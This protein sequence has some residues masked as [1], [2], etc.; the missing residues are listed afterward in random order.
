MFFFGGWGDVWNEFHP[1]QYRL[2]SHW[3]G[4]LLGLQRANIVNQEWQHQYYIYM[5][6]NIFL[7][8]HTHAHTHT[9]I[10]I[11]I[12][13]YPTAIHWDNDGVDLP[14]NG[15]FTCNSRNSSEPTWR[16]HTGIQKDLTSQNW[17]W[18]TNKYDGQWIGL[19]ENLQETGL[20]F[21]SNVIGSRLSIYLP[22]CYP[23]KLN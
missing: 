14:A 17:N 22:G 5:H 4:L 10:Y 21:T 7:C 23:T 20:F 12:C 3:D 13:M 16:T 19:R 1:C 2:W 9:Y 8:T 6:I 11:Y 15:T 18:I